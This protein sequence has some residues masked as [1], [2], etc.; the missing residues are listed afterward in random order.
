MLSWGGAQL[1]IYQGSSQRGV[2]LSTSLANLSD[3]CRGVWEPHRVIHC[4]RPCSSSLSVS[5]TFPVAVT[6][7]L[8]TQRRDLR[9]GLFR[10]TPREYNPRWWGRPGGR[11]RRQLLVFFQSGSTQLFLLFFQSR[12]Q[13]H[14]MVLPTFRVGF[15]T[16]IHS[17]YKL[18]CGP[19]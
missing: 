9:K 8:K 13:G 6:R 4:R 12:T 18:P 10:L 16:S 19:V 15:P 14:W 5:V 11:S 17:V 1:W 3:S 2:A 7:L